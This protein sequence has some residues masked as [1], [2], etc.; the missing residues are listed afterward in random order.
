MTHLAVSSETK[1]E[2]SIIP[3]KMWLTRPRNISLVEATFIMELGTQSENNQMVGKF[4]FLVNTPNYGF[5]HMS[6]TRDRVLPYV[7]TS[8]EE[9]F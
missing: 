5:T 3:F 6:N 1:H 9:L 2:V 8:R 4:K 7:Q